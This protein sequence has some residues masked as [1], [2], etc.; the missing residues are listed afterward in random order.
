M[1]DIKT[2]T[3]PSK[4]RSG[5][6]SE[7][8]T[9]V[10]GSTT[11]INNAGSSVD[12]VKE[13]DTTTLT[14]NNVLS[15]KRVLKEIADKGHSHDNKAVLDKL[16]QSV[17]DDSH[18]HANKEL[19]DKIDQDL[20]TSSDVVHKSISTGSF[21]SGLLGSG[22]MVDKIGNG[23]WESG[24]FRTFMSA[25]AFIYN[26]VEVNVGERWS[27][28]GF[29]KIKSVDT[30]KKIITQQLDDDELST[31]AVGD[32]CRGIFSDLDN[33]YNTATK[34]AD[35]CGFPT[36]AGFF[37]TYFSVVS[38][39]SSKK[40]SCTFRY[41]LRNDSTPSPCALMQA[42]QYGSF[43]DANRR[44]SIFQSNY[45]HAYTENLEG[46]NTWVISSPNITKRDGYLGKL[47][48]TNKNGS[49]TKLEGNGL[50]VQDN[51]YF[52]NAVIQLDPKTLADLQKDLTNYIVSLS[53]YADNFTADPSGNIVGGL[54]FED[55]KGSK[56]YRIHTAVAVR[57][58][59][60]ILTIADDGK[61]AEEGTYKLYVQAQGCT[62][63]VHNSTVFVTGIES[64]NDGIATSDDGT[65]HTDEWYDK[66]RKTNACSLIVIVDCEGKGSVTKQMNIGIKHT[67]DVFALA[68][69]DNEMS[70]IIYSI[71][72]AAY[73][74]FTTA[75]S[76][77]TVKHNGEAMKI[78]SIVIGSIDGITSTSTVASDKLS[79]SI[80]FAS[81]LTTDTLADSFVIPITVVATYAGVDYENTLYKKFVKIGGT[82]SYELSPS[83]GAISATYNNGVKVLNPTTIS[84]GIKCY[85]DAG[86]NY[87]LTSAQQSERSLVL[88]Y[89]TYN[90]S[91]MVIN[92]SSVSVGNS[93]SLSS[94]VY[95]I[96]FSLSQNNT[97]IDEETV[98]VNSDGK[99]A[100][101][102]IRFAKTSNT[103]ISDMSD[104]PTS[105]YKYIGLYSDNTLAAS[106][107]KSKYV[108]SPFYGQDGKGYELV[109]KLTTNDTKPSKNASNKDDVTNTSGGWYDDIQSVS[110][111]YAYMWV[112]RR[113]QTAGVWSN[114][115]TP[116]LYS[117][118]ASDGADGFNG[119]YKQTL[120][121]LDIQA[122]TKPTYASA[123]LLPASS[124]T[125]PA[126]QTSV[127]VEDDTDI[128]YTNV[129]GKF[130]LSGDN[131]K[132]PVTAHAAYSCL[133][134]TITTYKDNALVV[135]PITASSE[136]N[137][138]CGYVS[139]LDDAVSTTPRTMT[140]YKAKISG[141]DSQTLYFPIA[142]AGTHTIYVY[143][144]KDGSGVSGDDCIYFRCVVP[145]IYYSTARATMSTAQTVYQYGTWTDALLLNQAPVYA[146]LVTLE[147]N[148]YH[149]TSYNEV[150][151][152]ATSNIS[153]TQQVSLTVGQHKCIITSITVDSTTNMAVSLDTLN[154]AKLTYSATSGTLISSKTYNITVTGKYNSIT[155]TCNTT[156]SVFVTLKGNDGETGNLVYPAGAW[157]STS[158][159]TINGKAVPVVLYND[160]HYQLIADVTANASGNTTPNND[161]THWKMFSEFNA[162]WAKIVFAAFASMG[163][164]I[165]SGDYMISQQGTDASGN[166][167]SEYKNFTNE[168]GTAFMPNILINFLTGLFKGKKMEV[169]GKITAKQLYTPFTTYSFSSGDTLNITTSGTN[170]ITSGN[171]DSIL[172]LPDASLWNGVTLNIYHEMP[173][174]RIDTSFY[175][176]T[177][178]YFSYKTTVMEY[179]TKTKYWIQAGLVTLTAVGDH[180]YIHNADTSLLS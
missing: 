105:E 9:V 140:S 152:T 74:G 126:W 176:Q 166:A 80:S 51:V 63:E 158:A 145:R 96:I 55:D 65:T 30:D 125:Q 163:S 54:W 136:K 53:A 70:N 101:L 79:A 165:F 174:G 154:N 171:G 4:S 135:M 160:I 130:I 118:F 68:D 138:D 81:S 156:Y 83:V 133:K 76:G 121:R 24:T 12:V 119:E 40:G 58:N 93:I 66:M 10:Q 99:S 108:W 48:I 170:I 42:A 61:D 103:S 38:I 95:K 137:Y 43:T 139:N 64:F 123:D 28:N 18:I 91:G 116:S 77:L 49:T 14:D 44:A 146:P 177:S 102:H 89:T 5:N 84:C 167:T 1:I 143:Y 37:T 62:A 60:K 78:K 164:A 88:N 73:S 180:W 157:V 36:R 113:T 115:S 111:S 21:R 19:I 150:T 69:M 153:D 26:L 45:P 16:T 134:I 29:C 85:D 7:G 75:S 86:E 27:T 112:S 71:K 110:S 141:T 128:I 25:K 22:S 87:D 159:Y 107:D 168:N 94:D 20:S 109:Y 17:I 132:S 161:T 179:T 50:Y 13:L 169:E 162:I 39:L 90:Q 56:Q 172:N 8:S 104:T 35:D 52:G 34:D 6:Y 127:P 122:P 144:A 11:T 2:Y 147:H 175:I 131:I 92:T 59:N 72:N 148:A 178:T 98:F 117:R 23:E 151:G 15:S 106:S 57:N 173:I 142:T 46:V 31:M 114:W 47:T 129:V 97:T 100:Y 149:P 3:T 120:Y 41:A 33:S 67:E 32:I 82:A 124:V 155:Y